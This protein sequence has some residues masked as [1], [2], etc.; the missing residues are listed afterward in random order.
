MIIEKAECERYLP[1]IAK[2]KFLVPEDF[3]MSHMIRVFRDRL[4]L[5]NDK[6]TIFV[7]IISF[8]SRN[9][10]DVT[11]VLLFLGHLHAN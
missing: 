3:T 9:D 1:A 7:S 8:C 6:V 11:D 5:D 4:K 10:F 2:I